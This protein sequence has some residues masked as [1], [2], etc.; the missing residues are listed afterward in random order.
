[1]AW[2]ELDSGNGGAN[3]IAKHLAPLLK[4]DS[5][6]KEPQPASFQIAGG[7]PVDGKARVN[8]TLTNGREHRLACLCP[9][10]V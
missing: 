6:K 1:M 4:L 9:T 3:V 10:G 2:M 8:D 7:I 5:S